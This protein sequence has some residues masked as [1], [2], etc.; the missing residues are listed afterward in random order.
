MQGWFAL[1][2]LLR[3]PLEDSNAEIEG[4][5]LKMHSSYCN[6]VAF[7]LRIE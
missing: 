6:E 3:A 4:R 1:A 7:N 2:L 5:D